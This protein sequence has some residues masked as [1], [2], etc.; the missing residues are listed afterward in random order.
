[1]LLHAIVTWVL[2]NGPVAIWNNVAVPCGFEVLP[3]L[4]V[5]SSAKWTHL[6]FHLRGFLK[7]EVFFLLL[8][9]MPQCYIG[10]E[11]WTPFKERD[12]QSFWSKLW[13]LQKLNKLMKTNEDG[14]R[15]FFSDCVW[16]SSRTNLQTGKCCSWCLFII[17]VRAAFGVWAQTWKT[18]RGPWQNKA[19]A[20]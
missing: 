11:V 7:K 14:E 9:G 3:P 15:V 8:I 16:L 6:R 17:D 2:P 12:W 1:M 20:D 18:L 4:K 5:V 19:G 13:P 10:T